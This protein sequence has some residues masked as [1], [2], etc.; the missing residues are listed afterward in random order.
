[1]NKISKIILSIS[2]SAFC[3]FS[4]NKN[5]EDRNIILKNEVNILP[6]INE[7]Q[8]KAR[9][10]NYPPFFL[11]TLELN[12]TTLNKLDK[13]ESFYNQYLISNNNTY[14]IKFINNVDSL[15]TVYKTEKD[16]KNSLKDH[17]LSIV[18]FYQAYSLTNNTEYILIGRNL[19]KELI[20]NQDDGGF[21]VSYNSGLSFEDKRSI[22]KQI[23]NNQL[24]SLYTLYYI[25]QIE[26]S[27][28]AH[29]IY[30]KGLKTLR[31]KLR[32]YDS[33]F[34]SLYSK[35]KSDNHQYTFA[36]A[37]G[38]DP[39]FTHELVIIQL[40]KLYSVSNEP[41]IFE[42][43]HQFLKQDMGEFS[44]LSNQSKFKSLNASYTID[45]DN[46][47]VNFLDDELWSWG[48]YWST[49]KFPTTLYVEFNEEKNNI[50]AI[51]F[52]SIKENFSPNSFN[53]YTIKNNQWELAFYSDQI[54]MRNQNY[55]KTENYETFISTYYLPFPINSTKLKI[56]FLDSNSSRI[57]AIRELN[58]FY[59][60]SSEINYLLNR[61]K[62]ELAIDS[63][64]KNSH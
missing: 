15:S 50:E 5:S 33:Y 9:L 4:C 25:N 55:Y 29:L 57:I 35:S 26:Y 8:Y 1:M 46:F 54:L 52:Y 53:I 23:L 21:I 17:C 45:E 27:Q 58:V 10:N 11:S 48:Q 18:A 14:K 34:T 62:M 19:L 12:H 16:S 30:E 44:L 43:A 39:D 6:E 51:S 42:F 24:L 60:R 63:F 64:K 41:L 40:L 22:H 3:L 56:E 38:T 28:E 61:L 36:S 47:G 7:E 31:S 49:S 59:D 13:I 32:E 2:F 37:I 20:T